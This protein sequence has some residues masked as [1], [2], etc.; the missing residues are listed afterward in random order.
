VYKS[1]V[2]RRSPP[3]QPFLRKIY[4][5]IIIELLLHALW[6]VLY[7]YIEAQLK[8]RLGM[9]KSE[10]SKL[11][12]K[13][14]KKGLKGKANMVPVHYTP[15]EPQPEMPRYIVE[16]TISGEL[17][18]MHKRAAQL[19]AKG[20]PISVVSKELGVHAQTLRKWSVDPQFGE[21]FDWACTQVETAFQRGLDKLEDA[22][23]FLADELL[24]IIRNRGV[25]PGVRGRL[26]LEV[27][28]RVAAVRSAYKK[29]MEGDTDDSYE[30]ALRKRKTMV[31][32][33]EGEEV[34]PA[35]QMEEE[36]GG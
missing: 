32:N 15:L 30:A 8:V 23:P 14:A 33:S 26:A 29:P 10:K 27:M 13:G 18:Q 20:Y 35:E 3:Q 2:V 21:Y 11:A 1:S 22:A 12:E 4:F 25:A 7:L 34:P 5:Y 6:G 36:N 31:L 16:E 19:L 9:D 17:N 24:D 28:D